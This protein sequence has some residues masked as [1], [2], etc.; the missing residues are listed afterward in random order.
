MAYQGV[1]AYFYDHIDPGHAVELD[2][3]RWNQVVADVIWRG[4]EFFEE[5][6]GQ[7]RQYPLDGVIFSDNTP[8]NGYCHDCRVLPINETNTV[9]FTACKKPWECAMPYPRDPGPR[10]K[11]HKYRLQE[12]TNI[13]TCGLLFREYFSIRRDIEL[14]IIEQGGLLQRKIET[15]DYHPEYFLGYCKRAGIYNPIEFQTEDF[16]MKQIYGF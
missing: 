4:P 7:C 14:R 11:P 16:D 15:G 8:D 13:T 2:V 9:H 1:L 3:C 12:L 6:H 10:R 5:H